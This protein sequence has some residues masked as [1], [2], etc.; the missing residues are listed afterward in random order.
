MNKKVIFSSLL[1]LWLFLLPGNSLAQNKT[2]YWERYDVDITLLPNGD[3]RFV[4]TQALQFSGDTFS[5]G[6]MV[7]PLNQADRITDISV[8]EGDTQYRESSSTLS[9]TFQVTEEAGDLYVDWY[10]T[11][12]TG[13]H[14]YT[15]R[16]TVKG[17]VIVGTS[18]QGDG[19]Q[20]YWTIIPSDHPAPVLQSKVTV[21]LP[22]GVQPQVYEG[23]NDY[24]VAGYVNGT[25][26]DEVTITA[27]ED[28]ETITY[29]LD[30][31]IG[32]GETFEVRVQ[33][34][35]GLL[36]ISEPAWQQQQRV[37]DSLMLVVGGVSVL[38]LVGGVLGVVAL[39]YLYGRDPDLNLP[40]PE[41]LSE[42]PDNLSPAVVGTLIDEKADTRDV[43]S[44]LVH[45]AQREYLTISEGEGNNQ[46]FTLSDKGLEELRP[47]ERQFIQDF[48][49]GATART[50]DNLRY[51]FASKLPGLRR[52]L[53]EELSQQQLVPHSPEK[54]RTNYGCLGGF[55]LL[56]AFL[57]FFGMA[58]IL[59]ES[60]I[61]AAFCPPVALAITAVSLFIVSFFMPVKT[62]KGAEAAAKWKAFKN[63]LQNIEK[64]Q[65]I[66][67][68]GDIFAQYLPYAVAFGLE[69]SW[70]NKF[71]AVPTAPVPR[72]YRPYPHLYG[73]RPLVGGSSAVPGNIPSSGDSGGL[74]GM[75]DSFSGGLQSMSNSFTR[76]LNN[77]ATTMKS[78]R[79]PSSGSGGSGGF[80]GRSSRG[81]SGGGGR[82]SGGGGRR[83]FR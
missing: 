79:P 28:G 20:I 68:A 14:T 1:L 25:E 41:Y 59:P 61:G 70:I 55:I 30:S 35:H 49:A 65:D 39:W 45:L 62:A 37:G 13:L 16:Y 50:L 27:S 15:I 19:D 10:F 73:H 47:F 11:P 24:L 72:W 48:F 67:T 54:I 81:F 33:F 18:E 56:V 5:N 22:D 66:Q 80:S 40:V 7:I 57:S 42:P 9:G 4:E 83:G 43:L 74:Q 76:M 34:P 29:R 23:S 75:S 12:T 46:T 3:M 82:R 8:S 17:G 32:S 6:F 52:L 36:G 69:R 21:R 44:I 53:Y 51:Q 77:T 26:S 64:Y 38:L 31:P 78:V 71:A 58:F 2:F 60:A 63:Y